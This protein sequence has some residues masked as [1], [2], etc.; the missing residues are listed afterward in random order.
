ME[1]FYHRLTPDVLLQR[2]G[3]APIAYL[4]LGTLE[5]HG[6][7]LPLGSDMLQPL[8]LYA[9]LA[10]KIGGVVLPPIS[11]GPDETATIDGKVFFG[12]DFEFL[13][14]HEKPRQL[15]GS[16]YYIDDSVFLRYADDMVKQLGRAGVKILVG[17]GHGP[18]T[19]YFRRQ[20]KTWESRYGMRT[21]TMQE[22]VAEKEL[23]FM[24]DH[25][26]ANETSIMLATDPDLVRMQNLPTD[27]KQW[28]TGIMGADPRIHAS[29]EMGRRIIEANLRAMEGLLGE[30][31]RRL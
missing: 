29:A 27:P 9:D 2:L 13:T 31:L 7:H 30:E 23:G 15:P 5:Y 6:P 4:P 16:A 20:E 1:I 11:M 18:S 24:I 19:D 21:L 10:R 17:H 8:G 26:G 28:P 25:A 3:E 22:I 12:M 14:E